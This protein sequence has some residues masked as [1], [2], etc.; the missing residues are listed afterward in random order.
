MSGPQQDPVV[1]SD[2]EEL[3]LVDADD[4]EVGYASKAV[5]HD[6]D[7]VL[8]RA[9]SIFLRDPDGNVLLQQRAASKRLWPGY[10]ANSCCSHPRRGETMA[11]ATRRRLEQELR[12]ACDLEFLFTFT[13]HARFGDLGSEREMCSVFLGTSVDPVVPNATEIAGIRWVAPEDLDRELAERPELF[14]PWLLL[15]WPRVRDRLTTR[16]EPDATPTQG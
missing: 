15:E 13:Y 12:V 1:S 2:S 5:C 14:T 4:R 8:H 7:G 16:P 11:V 6:G 9:F 3:V 10:W